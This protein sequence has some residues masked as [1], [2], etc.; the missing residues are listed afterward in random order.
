MAPT[1]YY[2]KS[3]PLVPGRKVLSF[4]PTYQCTRCSRL[5]QTPNTSVEFGQTTLLTPEE[6]ARQVQATAPDIV[7]LCSPNNPTGTVKP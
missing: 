5:Q 2:N 4:P 1:K 3:T 7:F 6:A